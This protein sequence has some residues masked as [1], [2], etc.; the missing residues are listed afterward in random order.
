MDVIIFKTSNI[1]FFRQQKQECVEEV[2]C[3]FGENYL[4]MFAESKN[5]P[6]FA[7]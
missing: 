6:I 7:V 4:N 5:F 2:I 1:S 3:I